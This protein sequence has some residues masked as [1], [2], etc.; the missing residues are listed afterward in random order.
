MR[1]L[2][3]RSLSAV[4]YMSLGALAAVTLVQRVGPVLSVCAR[5]LRRSAGEDACRSCRAFHSGSGH[6]SSVLPRAR[7]AVVCPVSTRDRMRRGG[8]GSIVAC[9]VMSG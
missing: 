9:E 6:G 8:R 1:R 5:C 3:S 2:L 7:E 4:V